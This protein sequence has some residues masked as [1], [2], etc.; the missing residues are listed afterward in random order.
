MTMK[1][2]NSK[3]SGLREFKLTRDEIE[4][5]AELAK[6]FKE[7]NL[8]SIVQDSSSGIGVTTKVTFNLFEDNDTNVNI[9]D[10]KS[11]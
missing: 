1:D 4:K 7:V 6:H 8:F 10:V 5:L 3:K 11:W 9:T 2:K